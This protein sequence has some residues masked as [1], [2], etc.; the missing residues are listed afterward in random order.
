MTNIIQD[1]TCFGLTSRVLSRTL[2]LFVDGPG[3]SVKKI[4]DET[5]IV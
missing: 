3:F 1:L 5:N 4:I 2:F